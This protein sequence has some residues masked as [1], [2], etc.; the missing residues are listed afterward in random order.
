MTETRRPLPRQ[1]RRATITEMPR[2]SNLCLL[3][4]PHLLLRISD[5]DS[6]SLRRQI[7]RRAICE[8]ARDVLRSPMPKKT[9]IRQVEVVSL[10]SEE[11]I[12]A[13][14]VF[15]NKIDRSW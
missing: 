1:R 4:I 8:I 2:C 5:P 3:L 13:A 11:M 7:V 14:V 12:V 6:L 9:R 10:N 15:A